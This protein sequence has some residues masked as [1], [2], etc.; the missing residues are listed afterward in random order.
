MVSRKFVNLY[1]RDHT[2]RN[3]GKKRSAKSLH[4][5]KKVVDDDFRQIDTQEPDT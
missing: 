2:L 4:P 3:A 1:S 5:R